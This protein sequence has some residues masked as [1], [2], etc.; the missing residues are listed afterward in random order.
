[1]LLLLLLQLGLLFQQQVGRV[2][3]EDVLFRL[4]V[5]GEF[6]LGLVRVGLLDRVGGGRAG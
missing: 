2:A 3:V 5:L 6:G 4:G 1:M